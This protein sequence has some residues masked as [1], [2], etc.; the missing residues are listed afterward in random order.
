MYFDI[1]T[2]VIFLVESQIFGNSIPKSKFFAFLQRETLYPLLFLIRGY[3]IWLRDFVKLFVLGFAFL[4]LFFFCLVKLSELGAASLIPVVSF[5]I[6]LIPM[7]LAMFAAPSSFSFCGV[8]QKNVDS[9]VTF[10]RETGI[11]NDEQIQRIKDNLEIFDRR[12]RTRTIA[13]RS[14]L[15][16][17]WASVAFFTTRMIEVMYQH[18]LLPATDDYILLS[19]LILVAVVL[20]ALIECYSKINTL[21]FRTAQIGCNELELEK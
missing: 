6:F 3:E 9:V 4:P 8:N 2:R 17:C 18:R 11:H 10:L 20:Y 14:F 5:A 13:L 16:I 19:S 15:A 1:S 7:A 21:I 12:A